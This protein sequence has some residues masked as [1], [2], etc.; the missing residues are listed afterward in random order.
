M[1]IG[2]VKIFI[3]GMLSTTAAG[4]DC[5]LPAGA[6]LADTPEKTQEV[7]K[8]VRE[9]IRVFERRDAQTTGQYALWLER[10][11]GRL[12][13]LP[14]IGVDQRL[15]EFGLDSAKRLRNVA[16]MY[17]D[18]GMVSSIY[19]TYYTT[20]GGY[21]GYWGY[22]FGWYCRSY[23]DYTTRRVAT[24][25]AALFRTTQNSEVRAGLADTRICLTGDYGVEF[26]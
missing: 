4:R 15:V 25:E 16:L 3:A 5:S 14:L 1:R 6:S 17:R 21:E 26:R 9:E 11:A 7:Y 23:P 12:E 18:I 13:N 20:C 2:I 24:R 22:Y 19:R 8:T 10:S